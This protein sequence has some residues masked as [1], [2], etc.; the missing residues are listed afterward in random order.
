[1]R[2][3]IILII[4]IILLPTLFI[5]GISTWIIV[6]TTTFD[7]QYNTNSDYYINYNGKSVVY[8]GE[9]QC[10]TDSNGNLLSSIS[11][12]IVLTYRKI[13]QSVDEYADGLPIDAGEYFIYI[14][15][16]QNSSKSTDIY[17]KIEP[18][19]FKLGIVEYDY[20]DTNRTWKNI[21]EN[22]GEEKYVFYADD[23]ETILTEENMPSDYADY[24][25][26]KYYY[27]TITDGTYT[28]TPSSSANM[29]GGTYLLEYEMPNT[30]N[31]LV[32]NYEEKK[33]ADYD[34]EYNIYIGSTY[35][36]YKTVNV[37]ALKYTIEDALLLDSNDKIILQGNSTNTS[38]YV[39]T[40]FTKLNN[41]YSTKEF[42]LN[43]RELLVPADETDSYLLSGKNLSN[44]VYS[45]L[46]IHNN[47]IINVDNNGILSAAGEIYEYSV[48]KRRGII[49][50]DGTINVNNSTVNAY[51]Y[52]KKSS[53][54]SKGIIN[55]KNTSTLIDC[56]RIY[57]WPGGN[58][59]YNS[60]SKCMPVNAWSFHNTSCDVN[61]EHTSVFKIHAYLTID[62]KITK[63]TIN[64]SYPI[65]N[66]LSTDKPLFRVDS[67]STNS[68]IKKTT[69][70]ESSFYSITGSNQSKGQKDN[71]YIN[72]NYVDSA[73]SLDVS[74]YSIAT[75]TS[76]TC[77]IGYMD[78]ILESGVLHLKNAD[79]VFLPGT[80]V[81]INNGA[82]IIVDKDVDLSFETIEDL[83]TI[84][85]SDNPSSNLFYNHCTNKID[86]ALNI[87]G[88]LTLKSG[89]RIGGLI[90]PLKEGISLNLSNATITSTFT[91]V[92]NAVGAS[93]SGNMAYR[94]DNLP[95]AG[96]VTSSDTEPTSKSLLSKSI[97][98]SVKIGTKFYWNGV[99]SSY[100]SPA[101]TYDAVSYGNCIPSGTLLTLADGTQKKVED[102]LDTDM[103]L[104]FNHETGKFEAAPLI[105]V[106]RDEWTYYNVV[107]L[108]FSNGTKTRLIYE[109]GY[110][111]LTLNKYVYI[112]ESNYQDYIGHEFA[113]YDGDKVNSVTLTNSYITN[114][115]VGCYSPVTA[116][117]LNYIVDGYISMPG[118]I[119]G[120]FN[121]F[122]YNDDMTY[123]IEKMNEDIEKYGLY[124]YEDFKD[125]LPYEVYLAFPGP[126][127]KVSVEKGY[128]TFEEIIGYIEQ[129]LGRHGL[130]K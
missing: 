129:Y 32:Y 3:K 104:V 48:I 93:S 119:E 45:V 113:F 63:I 38:S 39:E 81:T 44:I 20:N 70:N 13:S 27:S 116:Y 105:F 47:V 127:L 35:F 124:T 5:F 64:D 122:E 17:F 29:V 41:A 28:Y 46:H 100:A 123:D 57:D 65:I 25:N 49:M 115:Y 8:N 99:V 30:N 26:K 125:Y 69:S 98:N 97:Y 42:N 110:F 107:N 114:E 72:G 62:L 96:Y 86:A 91:S 24:I 88:T 31:Y 23:G 109:H 12:N 14:N 56:M 79:Y 53:E 117:H 11:T 19:K 66:G 90:V 21:K 80:S 83:E 87:A 10:P 51:G 102:L 18:F 55:L 60:S 6:N 101:I 92:Y 58:T 52:I 76:V 74:G 7:P 40:A 78:V 67:S 54:K 95:L 15:D 103:L 82:E 121:I 71:L 120:L 106:D 85:T 59:A 4:F 1:M 126:Y 33:Y 16:S 73:F 68:Y 111:D 34:S 84:N 94:I 118:G 43:N 37:G 108:E 9:Q 130:N 22:I 2:K 50:N 112:T 77:C 36:K 75:N 128:I 89:G 61:I